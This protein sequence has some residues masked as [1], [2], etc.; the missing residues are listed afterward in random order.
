MTFHRYNS[1]AR[2]IDVSWG[3]SPSRRIGK[4][5]GEVYCGEIFVSRLVP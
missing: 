4:M 3:V 1:A 5:M 2:V